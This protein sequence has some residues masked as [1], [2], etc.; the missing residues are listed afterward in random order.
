[1]EARTDKREDGERGRVNTRDVDADVRCRA[2]EGGHEK[3][4]HVVELLKETGETSMVN[5]G[6]VRLNSQ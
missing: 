3:W 2:K 4:Q 1:M 5:G 6:N